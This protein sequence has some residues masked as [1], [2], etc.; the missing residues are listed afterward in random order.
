MMHQYD[1]L[2]DSVENQQRKRRA[3]WFTSL[4]GIVLVGLLLVGAYQLNNAAKM[5]SRLPEISVGEACKTLPAN[6]QLPNIPLLDMVLNPMYEPEHDRDDHAG[7]R[8]MKAKEALQHTLAFEPHDG[9]KGFKLAC[10]TSVS[11]MKQDPPG[12]MGT[13]NPTKEKCMDKDKKFIFVIEPKSGTQQNIYGMI[14]KRSCRHFKKPEKDGVCPTAS[15][16]TVKDTTDKKPWCQ[17]VKGKCT[18]FQ[19]G[20]TP[21]IGVQHSTF[22]GGAPVQAAGILDIG[23]NGIISNIRVQSGHYAPTGQ[24]AAF[25]VNYLNKVWGIPSNAYTM[26]V[27]KRK[28][29][30]DKMKRKTVPAATLETMTTLN[31][32][33][34]W[35]QLPVEEEVADWTDAELED[36]GIF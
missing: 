1:P 28:D 11:Y 9:K 3:R 6:D 26:T 27:Y 8:Y 29:G 36:Y 2:L 31:A 32:D 23:D 13:I 18:G 10:P 24:Q 15:L 7:V 16:F 5:G 35:D 34:I 21:V 19:Q 30:E 12:E 14:K 20:E 25:I 22:L 17:E 33:Q 4:F